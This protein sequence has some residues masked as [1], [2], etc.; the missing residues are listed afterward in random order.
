M[1]HILSHFL[2]D[3]YYPHGKALENSREMLGESATFLAVSTYKQHY[4]L[5]SQL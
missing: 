2:Q 4:K 5:S 1:E 3:P